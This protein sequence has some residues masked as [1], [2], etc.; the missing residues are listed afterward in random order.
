MSEFFRISAI[1]AAILTQPAMACSFDISFNSNFESGADRLAASEVRRLAGW[2]IDDPGSFENKQG[3][4]II[5]YEGPTIGVSHALARKRVSHLEQWLTTFGAPPGV[6]SVS[7]SRFTYARM[8]TKVSR[9]RASKFG[10]SQPEPIS[11]TS[12]CCAVVS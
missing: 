11:S 7:G 9:R 10:P 2:M 5:L 6:I 8:A 1:A 12:V 4:H 3:F